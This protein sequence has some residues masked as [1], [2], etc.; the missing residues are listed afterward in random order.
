MPVKRR[1]PPTFFYIQRLTFLPYSTPQVSPPLCHTGGTA[2]SP[3]HA[4]EK[5]YLRIGCRGRSTY[6]E[7]L[8]ELAS[9]AVRTSLRGCFDIRRKVVRHLSK[10]FMAYVAKICDICRA[11]RATKFY[12]KRIKMIAVTKQGSHNEKAKWPQHFKVGA[13]SSLH[14]FH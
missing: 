9:S 1:L 11:I 4:Y 8:S 2:P 14:P 10:R 12:G 6:Y 13:A 5:F 3:Y 7:M